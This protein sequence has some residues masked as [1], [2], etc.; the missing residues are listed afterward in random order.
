MN[1]NNNTINNEYLL[2]IESLEKELDRLEKKTELVKQ[3][4]RPIKKEIMISEN[5]EIETK[6]FEDLYRVSTQLLKSGMLPKAYDTVEKIM[7]G[8][9]L[10]RELKLPPLSGLRQ[11]AIINGSPSL[12]GEL[13]LAL[14]RNSGLLE[15]ID[16]FLIDKDYKRICFENR[17]L[18]AEI[19]AA[20]CVIKR[21]E[22]EQKSFA[23]T[24]MDADLNP[25]SRGIVW[26]SY[27]SIMMKRR[28]RSIALKD[29]FGDVLGGI[30]IA[31]YDYDVIPKAGQEISVVREKGSQITLNDE[32]ALNSINQILKD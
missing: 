10:V 30:A 14:V 28:A 9:T 5:G 8:V 2:K 29:E 11:L 20:I 18:D 1:E 24:K 25:N 6:T 19:Y 23:Y 12:W 4:E 15:S 17:N 26:K 32:E 7:T 27:R 21:K 16:E 22:C 31:E 3:D 13:P